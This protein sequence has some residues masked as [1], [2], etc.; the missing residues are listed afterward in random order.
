MTGECFWYCLY[1]FLHFFFPEILFMA[2]SWWVF[3]LVCF[4]FLMPE[5]STP[6]KLGEHF[7]E[8]PNQK[9]NSEKIQCQTPQFFTVI[10]RWG[11]AVW[12]RFPWPVAIL[13]LI[14]DWSPVIWLP[15]IYSFPININKSLAMVT[16]GSVTSRVACQPSVSATYGWMCHRDGHSRGTVLQGEGQHLRRPGLGLGTRSRSPCSAL[17]LLPGAGTGVPRAVAVLAV[18]QPWWCGGSSEQVVL[19]LREVGMQKSSSQACALPDK[20][21]VVWFG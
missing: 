5:T 13:D 8:K 15:L 6:V 2:L 18:V 10:L 16:P 14:A 9:E 3:V 11:Y 19:R 20:S 21:W 1:N 7:L 4:V 17:G 12:K